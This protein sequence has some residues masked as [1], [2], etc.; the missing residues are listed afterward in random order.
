MRQLLRRRL[1][2]PFLGHPDQVGHRA[3]SRPL[4]PDSRMSSTRHAGRSGRAW[5]RNALADAT[6]VVMAPSNDYHADCRRPYWTK[7]VCASGND[8]GARA[9]VAGVDGLALVA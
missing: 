6:A 4:G 7:V 2:P 3:C 8:D 1:L 5:S 9:G